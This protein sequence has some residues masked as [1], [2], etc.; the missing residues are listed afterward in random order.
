VTV[1]IVAIVVSAAVNQSAYN[2]V[3]CT[4]RTI[5]ADASPW[6]LPACANVS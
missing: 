1:P 2:R 3:A 6:A 4:T 5:A